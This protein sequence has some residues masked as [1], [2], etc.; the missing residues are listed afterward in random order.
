[1]RE[2][3]V[4][5][6]GSCLVLRTSKRQSWVRSLDYKLDGKRDSNGQV[7]DGGGGVIIMLFSR[8]LFLSDLVNELGRLLPSFGEA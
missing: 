5:M 4:S 1:M 8:A 2:L 3:R 6:T 7:M